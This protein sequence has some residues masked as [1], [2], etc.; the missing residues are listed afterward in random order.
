[1][2]AKYGKYNSGEKVCMP[3]DIA[4]RLCGNNSRR[5]AVAVH[6]PA[7]EAREHY[8]AFNHG[9]EATR[10]ALQQNIA[11]RAGKAVMGPDHHKMVTIADEV[12]G[13]DEPPQQRGPGRPPR[14][15]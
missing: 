13:A 3:D 8:Q 7:E 2:T 12:K 5:I 1:M 6:V 4:A 11:R 15:S 10:L 14:N 9:I